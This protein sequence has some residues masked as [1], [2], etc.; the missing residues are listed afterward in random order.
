MSGNP[1]NVSGNLEK[2]SK[3][4]PHIILHMIKLGDYCEDDANKIM[5]YLNDSG[6]KGDTRSILRMVQHQVH[7]LEGRLS[8][9]KGV[10][11][12]FEKLE[13]CV[14]VL[15][16]VLQKK[17]AQ[18]EF[19]DMFLKEFDPLMS[20]HDEELARIIEKASGEPGSLAEEDKSR[21]CE[22]AEEGREL[23]LYYDAAANILIRN[24]ISLGEDVGS[25]LDDPIVRAE[26]DVDDYGEDHPLIRI[27]AF[28]DLARRIEVFVDEIS[29]GE[30][31][32]LSDEFSEMYPAEFNMVM[33]ISKVVHILIAGPESRR[34]DMSEFSEQCVQRMVDEGDMVVVDLEDGADH[35]VRALEKRGIVKV[36]GNIIKWKH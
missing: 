31:P 21:I 7:C 1:K 19:K 9:L 34:A 27:T 29:A 6:I 11:E 2:T 17:P 5:G 36:K 14:E 4:N 30:A 24:E 16:S 12:D 35:L 20:E 25:R 13:R 3:C 18:E 23:K 8:E 28:M 10:A 26:V 15:R 22:L 33:A 32:E